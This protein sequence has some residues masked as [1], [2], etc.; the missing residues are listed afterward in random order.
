MNDDAHAKLLD[1]LASQKFAGMSP[2]LREELI[3]FYSEPDAPYATKRHPKAWDA[4]QSELAGLK[5]TTPSAVPA[6][7]PATP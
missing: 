1:K 7:G 5:S 4:V 3:H 6:N 2:E